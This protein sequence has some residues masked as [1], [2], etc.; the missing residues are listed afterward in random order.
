MVDAATLSF[1][2]D[3]VALFPGQGSLGGGAGLAWQTSRHWELVHRVSDVANVDVAALLLSASDEDVVRTDRAQLA[4]FA[5][6]LVGYHELLDLELR[7]RYLVGHSLGEFSSLVA[8]G[9]LSLEEGARL[10]G[11]RGSAMARAAEANQGSMV[12]LMGGD[13]GAR[14]A[15]DGLDNVWVANINGT[16]QIVVSGTRA[17]LDD[18]LARHKDLG[19][20]RAT[21]L[22]VG[23]AFHSPLMAPAQEELDKAL[24]ETSWGFTEATLISN[25]DA[26]MHGSPEEWRELLRR[27]LTSPVEFLD[28]IL[29]LPES[30]QITI[31]MPPSG[32]LTGLTKRIRPFE[33]QIA[34]STLLELQEIAL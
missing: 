10:I 30:V 19:W 11:V 4:T 7:P 21:P 29:N 5:L 1:R 13:G 17:G 31:E 18:L 15:L 6:S 26:K 20:R 33:V 3:V 14:E 27:Q 28:A 9:L 16:G 8:S 34:P 2:D 22:T 24:D 23:G 32:V 25:V 12:A